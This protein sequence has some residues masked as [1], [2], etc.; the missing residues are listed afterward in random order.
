[1]PVIASIDGTA[2]RIYLDPAAA[3]GG[4]LSFHTVEQ[5]YQ[6]YRALRRTDEALRRFAPLLRAE[7]LVPKGGGKFTPRYI[8]LLAGT[9]LVIP[10]GVDVVNVSGEVLTDDQTAPFATDLLTGPVVINYEPPEAEVIQVAG[11]SG[12]SPAQATQLIELWRLLGLD[13]AAPLVATPAAI[14]AGPDIELTLTGDGV[15]SSTATRQP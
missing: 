8:V 13:P 11:G 2:R 14:N 10:V 5:I 7:G 15:T 9:K 3:V 1:M 4:V 6:E 12:L